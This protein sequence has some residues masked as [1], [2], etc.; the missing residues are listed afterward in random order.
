MGYELDANGTL[1]LRTCVLQGFNV[2]WIGNHFSKGYADYECQLLRY[3]PL[4]VVV[5]Q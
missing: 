5:A 1:N 3:S 4:G 2:K